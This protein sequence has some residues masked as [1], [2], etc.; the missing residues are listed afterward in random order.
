[1]NFVINVGVSIWSVS[2]P[3]RCKG[4]TNKGEFDWLKLEERGIRKKELLRQQLHLQQEENN[5]LDSNNNQKEWKLEGAKWEK[6][7][8]E[9]IDI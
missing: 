5:H 6:A 4:E 8:N 9:L 7:I 2:A 1:M 3:S